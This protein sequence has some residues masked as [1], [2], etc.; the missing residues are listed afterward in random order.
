[1]GEQSTASCG[2]LDGM[3]DVVAL[4]EPA[5]SERVTWETCPSCGTSAALG[6]SGRLGVEIPV[7]FDCPAGC[8]LTEEQIRAVFGHSHR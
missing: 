6:W 7:E 2:L 8:E 4:E 3:T 1:M 5:T